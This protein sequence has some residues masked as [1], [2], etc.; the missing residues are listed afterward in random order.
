MMFPLTLVVL[1]IIRLR[2]KN[3]PIITNSHNISMMIIHKKY[4]SSLIVKFNVSQSSILVSMLHRLGC[5]KDS[6]SWIRNIDRLSNLKLDQS[7]VNLSTKLKNQNFAVDIS[8][9]IFAPKK[10]A[11]EVL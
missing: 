2:F 6:L 9:K 11:S 5:L 8:Y 10:K 1:F 3:K 4:I 7:D